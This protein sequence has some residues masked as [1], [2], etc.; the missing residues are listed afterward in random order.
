V[1]DDR[2]NTCSRDPGP[3]G[4]THRPCSSAR[5]RRTLLRLL[6]THTGPMGCQLCAPAVGS[7]LAT[8]VDVTMDHEADYRQPFRTCY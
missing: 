6:L 5:R 8:A 4:G 3:A 2:P 1:S 7:P